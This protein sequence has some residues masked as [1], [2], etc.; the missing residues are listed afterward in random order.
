MVDIHSLPKWFVLITKALFFTTIFS[1]LFVVL[2]W[3]VDYRYNGHV[4]MTSTLVGDF[5]CAIIGFLLLTVIYFLIKKLSRGSYRV[6]LV[7]A[8]LTLLVFQVVLISQYQFQMGWDPGTVKSKAQS[9]AYDLPYGDES[10]DEIYLN[11]FQINPNNSTITVLYA[12]I[13]KLAYF[14]FHNYDVAYFCLIL[15]NCILSVITGIVLFLVC[16]KITGRVSCAW[17][18]W[19]VF[20][21]FIGLNPWLSVPYTDGLALILPIGLLG[22]WIWDPGT[23]KR[24]YVKW[25]LIAAISYWAF[26]IKPQVFILFLVFLVVKI[27]QVIYGKYTGKKIFT[28]YRLACFLVMML[29]FSISIVS[30]SA[31]VGRFIPKN[32][33]MATP[34]THF[35]MMGMNWNVRGEYDYNDMY[36]TYKQLGQSNKIKYNIDV[37]TDRLSKMGLKGFINLMRTKMYANYSD[38]LFSWGQEIEM[39]SN[40]IKNA[41]NTIQEFYYPEPLGDKFAITRTI[42][43]IIWLGLLMLCLFSVFDKSA[44]TAV[45]V[46]MLGIIGLTIYELLFEAR[47]RYLFTYGPLYILLATMGVKWIASNLTK[48]KHDFA[49]KRSKYASC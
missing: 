44:K 26:K 23:I 35:L 32:D 33:A 21:V 38:G 10:S 47:A 3:S 13:L 1:A 7:V 19:A 29:S 27:L 16:K 12:G 42:S 40:H 20:A 6:A 5:T 46:C 49:M 17:F 41:E 24:R 4:E 39:F 11:Y 25:A 48:L 36:A 45:I 8:S 22:L 14:I 2:V 31:V 37:T 43:Q 18:S 9:I 15:L 30:L 34:V 28:R